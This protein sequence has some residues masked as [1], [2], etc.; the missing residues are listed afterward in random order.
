CSAMRSRF[1]PFKKFARMLRSHLDGILPWT[2][3]RLSSGAVE[4]MNNKVKSI[5]H[6]S[7]GFRTAKYF[8][9]N[10]YRCCAG[11]PLPREG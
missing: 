9:A 8:I 6:R 10:I 2:K 3:L 4:G 5:S 11:L 1:E 7:F